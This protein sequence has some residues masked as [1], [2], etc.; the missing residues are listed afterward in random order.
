MKTM[1][2][3]FQGGVMLLFVGLIFASI[4]VSMAPHDA[5]AATQN[6]AGVPLV[7]LPVHIDQ[8]TA[9]ASSVASIKVP[10]KMKLIGMSATA[11]AA[12]GVSDTLTVNL[13]AGDSPVIA[14]PLAVS[15]VSVSEATISTSTIADETVIHL[16]T[17]LSAD[18]AWYDISILLT[19]IPL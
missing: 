6:Y 7:T 4:S 17:A 15:S 1:K 2:N 9:S 12:S 10:A 3:W 8:A 14:A 5:L 11:R 13:R 18:A 19:L 16:D